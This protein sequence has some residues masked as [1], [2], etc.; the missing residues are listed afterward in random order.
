MKNCLQK[1]KLCLLNLL[2]NKNLLNTNGFILN[3]VKESLNLFKSLKELFKEIYYRN[4]KIE[5]AERKQD[6]FIVV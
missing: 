5:D 6:E 4:L 3:P 2:I 1:Q